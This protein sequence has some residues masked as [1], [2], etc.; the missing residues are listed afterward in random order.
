MGRSPGRRLINGFP[1]VEGGVLLVRFG[2]G[3]LAGAV[4]VGATAGVYPSIRA[5]RLTRTEALNAL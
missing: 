4:A 2:I 1:L 3:G 5:A